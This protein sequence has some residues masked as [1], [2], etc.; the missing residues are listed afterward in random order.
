V[1]SEH[2]DG[3]PNRSTSKSSRRSEAQSPPDS[4]IYLLLLRLEVPIRLTIGALGRF[5]FPAGWYVYTGTSRRNLHARLER[6]F[7]ARKKK[8]W[9]IDFLTSAAM[10]TPVGAVMFAGETAEEGECTLNRRVGALLGLVQFTPGF[11]ASDCQNGCGAHLWYTAR[12][13]SLLQLAGVAPGASYLLPAQP[14][15]DVREA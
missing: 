11:G 14:Q 9:H 15:P 12:P 8:R 3:K 10:L 13:V 2:D 7:A 6:H 1:R 5:S 4:G